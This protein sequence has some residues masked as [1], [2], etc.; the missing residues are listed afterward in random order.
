MTRWD[1]IVNEKLFELY[2]L[3][4]AGGGEVLKLPAIIFQD[5]NQVL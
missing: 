4:I 5:F 2:L 3:L 1:N